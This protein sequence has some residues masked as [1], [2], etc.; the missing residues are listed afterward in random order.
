[1]A[2]HGDPRLT[3]RILEINLEPEGG[4]T[5]FVPFAY[6]SL[7]AE[8]KEGERS[9]PSHEMSLCFFSYG[10]LPSPFS[11]QNYEVKEGKEQ[12]QAKEEQNMVQEA[13][14]EE[15]GGGDGAGE[16]QEGPQ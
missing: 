11:L 1:M 5:I 2:A 16:Q 15:G 10:S 8:V 7:R 6:Y 12:E 9:E 4:E 3:E 13:N 14:Q